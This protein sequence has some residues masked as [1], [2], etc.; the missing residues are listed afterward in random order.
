[1]SIIVSLLSKFALSKVKDYIK[2]NKLE[3]I[4]FAIVIFCF[5]VIIGMSLRLLY[6]RS[7]V[8][9]LEDNIDKLEIKVERLEITNR[10]YMT[11]IT[12]LSNDIVSQK[13]LNN[14][15]IKIVYRTNDIY[16]T[17]KE[18]IQTKL[19]KRDDFYFNEIMSNKV[20][21]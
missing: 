17:N 15:A 12:K 16:Y 4:L 6:R 21:Q 19:D 20:K 14:T 2:N 1:M 7:Q 11:D 9:K 5:L 8:S 13:K 3:F 18:I 10:L